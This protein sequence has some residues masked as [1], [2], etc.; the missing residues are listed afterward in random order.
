M[1]VLAM[2]AVFSFDS[3]AAESARPL[4]TAE[5]RELAKQCL[6]EAPF[7]TLRAIAKIESA[8]NPLAISINYPD[9]AT[10][11]LGLDDGIVELFRQPASVREAVQWTKWFYAR[12][13]TV[14]IGLMQVNAENLPTL[15][16]SLEQAFE[17]CANLKAGWTILNV[18][19]RTAAAV[20]GK[21]QL[22]LHA[23]IS[24][25]NSGSLTAGFNNGYVEKVLAATTPAS[26]IPQ[27]VGLT[28]KQQSALVP[29]RE[30]PQSI[31]P[32]QDT[33]QEDPNSAPT[34]VSWSSKVK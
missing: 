12:G 1:R 6:P 28:V 3:F 26:S 15:G 14:S 27:F 17:P 18:K 31:P 25:Y 8:Y 23:A 9:R 21:G 34:Q 30:Y 20:I 22:A 4:S 10:A 16:L 29:Q 19:Y 33:A 32:L 7:S 13:L 11:T 24:S 5:F 2:L